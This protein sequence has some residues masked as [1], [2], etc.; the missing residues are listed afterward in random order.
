MR[1]YLDYIKDGDTLVVSKDSLVEDVRLYGIDCPE[2]DQKPYGDLARKRLA[3]LLEPYDE[4][5]V[6][7]VDRDHYNRIVGEV[8]V[9]RNCINT[10]LLSEGYAFAYRRYLKGEYRER[11]LQAEEIARRHKLQFWR[12]PNFEKPWDY[13]YRN[14]R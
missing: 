14:R 7:Q 8:W 10:Q 3:H 4:I 9:E 6:I 13:R 2:L 11:Y 5:E 1:F 12:E